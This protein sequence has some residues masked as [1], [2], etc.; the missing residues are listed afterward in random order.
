M[1]SRTLAI[2]ILVTITCITFV[3][4]EKVAAALAQNKSRTITRQRVSSEPYVVLDYRV[5]GVKPA[6][7][8]EPF[9]EDANWLQ[10]LKFTIKCKSEVP[11][12][13]MDVNIVFPETRSTGS[14]LSYDWHL[15][16]KLTEDASL[17]KRPPIKLAKDE[18]IDFEITSDRLPAIFQGFARMGFLP[19]DITK[20][21]IYIPR[22]EFSDK[23]MW[24]V[25][26]L[27]KF[28]ETTKSNHTRLVQAV[29]GK[30]PKIAHKTN[31]T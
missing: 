21:E 11:I 24:Y 4:V 5:K 19:N 7:E 14:L 20:V 13:Y 29:V 23:K 8:D 2:T 16:I 9:E 12:T 27:F 10:N 26:Q 17:A 22:V 31:V 3:L 28:D 15:G 1:K 25:D 30:H 18:T 6:K